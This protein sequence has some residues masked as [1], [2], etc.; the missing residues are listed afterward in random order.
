MLEVASRTAHVKLRAPQACLVVSRFG[1]A[2]GLWN[3]FVR[4]GSLPGSIGT[5]CTRYRIR[6]SWEFKTEQF[7]KF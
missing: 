4:F 5:R 6:W 3:R 1:S 2:S 7:A